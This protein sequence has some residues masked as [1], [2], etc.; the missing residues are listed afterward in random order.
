MSAMNFALALRI[1][2]VPHLHE[3]VLKELQTLR[4]H[5]HKAGDSVSAVF[6]AGGVE[7]WPNSILVIDSPLDA[8]SPPAEHFEWLTGLFVSN[9]GFFRRLDGAAA[10]IDVYCAVSGPPGTWSLQMSHR[11]AETLSRL[12]AGLFIRFVTDPVFRKEQS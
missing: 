12:R 4:A 11:V 10:R 8:S 2:D 6:A 9:E 7:V 3:E 5:Y 1:H